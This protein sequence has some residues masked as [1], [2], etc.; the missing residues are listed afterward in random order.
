MT[1]HDT[2]PTHPGSAGSGVTAGAE[3][4]DP[5]WLDGHVTILGYLHIAY[6]VISLLMALFGSLFMV[7]GGILSG[8]QQAMAITGTVAVVVFCFL[9]ILSVPGLVTGA[10]LLQRRPWA[11]ILVLILAFFYLFNFPLGT[12]L[13]VYS[14]YILLRPE[15]TLVF[16]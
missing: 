4:G 3:G 7:M 5:T 12:A 14:F 16:R 11:R 6:S 10:F 8:D 9:A 2:G 15:A 13:G 1:D